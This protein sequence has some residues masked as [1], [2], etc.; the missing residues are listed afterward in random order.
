MQD[1][2][3]LFFTDKIPVSEKWKLIRHLIEN[4]Y[5]FEIPQTEYAEELSALENT[6]GLSL[7]TSVREYFTLS[8]QL[9]ETA[10]TY[11]NGQESNAF[12][13]VFRDCL[14][15][16]H[17]QEHEAVTL[18]IQGEQDIYWAVKKADIHRENPE[19]CCY[20]LDYESE[21]PEKFDFFGLSHASVTA[22]VISHILSYLH[23]C[24]SFGM[25]IEDR[26]SLRNMLQ[27]NLKQH[28]HF[29][30]L[31]IFEDENIIAYFSKDLF[32]EDGYTL[33]F[34]LRTNRKIETVPAP[35]LE[36]VKNRKHSWTSNGFNNLAS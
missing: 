2:K 33:I 32:G 26:D 11:E 12:T 31:E 5:G 22:F 30:E 28:T 10:F 19:I 3:P 13:C 7:P 25:E 35:I 34:H 36:L 18:M 6:L 27:S 21:K 15:I 16:S 29:E 20:L 24:S 9:S 17:L 23:N 1:Y 8:R 4:W 14:D